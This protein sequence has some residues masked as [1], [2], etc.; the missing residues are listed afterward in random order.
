MLTTRMLPFLYL[1]EAVQRTERLHNLEMKR[2]GIGHRTEVTVRDE[3]ARRLEMRIVLLRDENTTLQERIGQRDSGIDQLTAQ[4][5]DLRLQLE[6]SSEQ[7]EEQETQL[8]A[9]ARELLSLKV[10]FRAI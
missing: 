4:C 8:R 10:A 6:R 2:Q 1:S 3:V 5:D 7:C 9:Q